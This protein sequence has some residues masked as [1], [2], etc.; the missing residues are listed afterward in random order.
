MLSDI[1]LDL[2]IELN[3][4]V[5]GN[6]NCGG[7]HNHYPYMREGRVERL[8]AVMVESLRDN[9]NNGHEYADEAVLENTSPDDLQF[10][11][12]AISTRR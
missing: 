2:N 8:E 12:I 10:V 1:V 11:R 3:E 7:F 6:R 5:H 9:S 4:T